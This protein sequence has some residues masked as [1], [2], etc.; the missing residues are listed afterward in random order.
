MHAYDYQLFYHD[1]RLNA[2]ERVSAFWTRKHGYASGFA[3]AQGHVEPR[4]C[5]SSTCGNRAGCVLLIMLMLLVVSL[6]L[7][8]V[9]M[10]VICVPLFRCCCISC[11]HGCSTCCR[12][13]D[14]SCMQNR[15]L[16]FTELFCLGICCCCC[17]RESCRSKKKGTKGSSYYSKTQSKS[18]NFS[19]YGSDYGKDD[20]DGDG[21][22]F[23]L[24][25][26]RNERGGFELFGSPASSPQHH[27]PTSPRTFSV[28]M[29]SE[30]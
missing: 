16:T 9:F 21:D 14:S 24:V 25:A 5:P 15:A 17:L 11:C 30:L 2:I 19:F 23:E 13:S 8:F 12:E 28:S 6:L 26:S 20:G 22:A 18:S 3:F 10:M 4:S 27:T 29:E 1:I 7:W